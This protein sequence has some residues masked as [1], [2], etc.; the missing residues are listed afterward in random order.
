ME[1][2]FLIEPFS[3]PLLPLFL[4]VS[5]SHFIFGTLNFP[6]LFLQGFREFKTYFISSVC[7][8]KII[9]CM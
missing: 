4:G 9:Q 6:E 3:S 5:S 7:V 8:F 1:N 2:T